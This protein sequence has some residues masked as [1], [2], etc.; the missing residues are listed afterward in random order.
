MSCELLNNADFYFCYV[1]KMC[2]MLSPKCLTKILQ[3]YQGM[4]ELDYPPLYKCISG[5]TS[6]FGEKPEAGIVD[7]TYR[8]TTYLEHI[9]SHKELLVVILRSR[10]LVLQAL[11]SLQQSILLDEKGLD[12][13]KICL[14]HHQSLELAHPLQVN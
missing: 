9:E 11:G 7:N 12:Q 14:K 1:I 6:F 4:P 8:Y 2:I 10:S 5:V 13:G 3:L